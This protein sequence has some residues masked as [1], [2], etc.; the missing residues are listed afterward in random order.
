MY[1]YVYIYIYICI[2]IYKCINVYIYIN[3]Y[4]YMCIFTCIYVFASGIYLCKLRHV[5]LYILYMYIST[6]SIYIFLYV[7][8]FMSLYSYKLRDV[9]RM[10]FTQYIIVL[11]RTISDGMYYVYMNIFHQQNH[12]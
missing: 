9:M 3:I 10:H 12:F 7:Y 6:Y 5:G 11:N 4:T 2:Y 1:T 8:I